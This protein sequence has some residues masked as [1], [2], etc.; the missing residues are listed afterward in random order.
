M[1][2]QENPTTGDRRTSGSM[3][4]LAGL[5]AALE[6]GLPRLVNLALERILLA[7]AIFI[8]YGE[9]I[10]L[11]RRRTGDAQRLRLLPA[12]AGC[13]GPGWTGPRQKNASKKAR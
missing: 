6:S 13:T 10:P 11:I 9:G 7:H 4:S 2:F 1:H 8:G 5:E 3:A 12:P